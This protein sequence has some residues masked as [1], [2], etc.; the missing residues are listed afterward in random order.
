MSVLLKLIDEKTLRIFR[1]LIKNKGQYFHLNKLSSE[2]KVPI[3][4]TMRIV[5]D[6][7]DKKLVEQ[8]I[9]GKLK[10]YKINEK[11]TEEVENIFR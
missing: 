10:I 9:V 1:V 8:M 2:A 4:T 3:S 6:L 7:V 11:E 5:K